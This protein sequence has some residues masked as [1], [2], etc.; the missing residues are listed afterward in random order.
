MNSN[1]LDPFYSESENG[2]LALNNYNFKRFLEHHNFIKNKPNDV[3]GFNFIKKNGIFLEIVDEFEIKDFVL[4]YILDNDLGQRVYNLMT[5]KA[6]TFTRQYLSMLTTEEIKVIRDTKDTAY[7]FY[8]NGVMEVTKEGANLKP[9]TDFGLSIWEDQVIKRNFIEADHH[10]SEFRT[11]VWKIAGENVDRYNTLQTVIGYLLHSYNAGGDNKAVILND[12][13]ISDEPNGRSGKGLLCNMVGKLKKVQALDGKSF[14]FDAAFPYQAI[15]TDCQVMVFDDVKKGFP[16]IN[17]FSVI[18]EGISITYKG[19]D[20]IKLPIEDSPK[21]VIT[22]NYTIKGKGG[23]FEARK[24]EVELSPFFNANHTPIQYFGHRLYDDW[25]EMEKARF[26][27]YMIECL[28]K[29]L[30]KGLL[31]YDLISLPYKQLEV[32]ITKELMECIKAIEKGE[33]INA[34]EFYD[35]YI[36]Y[37]PKKWDAKTK[38]MVTKD[39]KRYCDFYGLDYEE[40]TSNG[41][42]KFIIKNRV[43]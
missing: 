8:Q 17:L 18:T 21:V 14:R 30:D 24:F 16:F 3:S 39:I 41:V 27:S 11:F 34:N 1:N 35:N 23:S 26:D 20:T 12:E 19:K 36:T 4:D 42:K 22:T 33:Y 29:Y 6:S 32:D 43:I 10:Q 31:T 2:K 7:L 25:D 40:M 38:N 5:G 37:I 28:K 9:Y 15:K 13:L